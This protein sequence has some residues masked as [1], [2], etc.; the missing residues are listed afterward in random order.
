MNIYELF[1]G[2]G[3][4]RKFRVL[5]E[6]RNQVKRFRE[7][8]WKLREE[9]KKPFVNWDRCNGISTLTNTEKILSYDSKNK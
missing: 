3:S 6:N 8:I 2:D 1:L 9:G 4:G 7:L 5:I